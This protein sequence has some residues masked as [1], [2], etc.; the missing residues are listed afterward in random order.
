MSSKA[1]IAPT[2]VLIPRGVDLSR[3]CVL[4]SDQYSSVRDYWQSV[5]EY[6]GG[7]PSTLQMIVP[8]VYLTVESADELATRV[9]R[10][11]VAMDQALESVFQRYDNSVIYVERATER[12]KR[13]RSL[14]VG[15]DL[16]DYSFTPHEPA[17]I[18][19]SEETVLER[20]P[21]REAVRAQASVELPHVQVLF[22]DPL[23]RVFSFIDVAQETHDEQLQPVY[24]TPLMM[25]GGVVRG[26]RI[27]G[28]SVL[29]RNLNNAL[30]DLDTHG[31][32]FR[33]VVGDG[34]HS[35]AAARSHWL[36][37]K[38]AGAREDH[39]ARFALVELIEVH[40]SGLT[41]EPI[42]RW[43]RGV[44]EEDLRDAFDR[45]NAS[46]PQAKL[47]SVSLVCGDTVSEISVAQ[48]QALVIES[49]QNVIDEL[50]AVRNLDPSYACEY[51]HGDEEL[52][53]LVA[54]QGGVG[55]FLPSIDRSALFDYV[56]NRGVMPRKSFS[57]GEAEEKRYYLE[58]RR[59]I[60]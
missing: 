47:Q 59:I 11:R 5:E 38:K 51:I 4:A 3:W 32:G 13:R 40:D 52:K 23:N 44:S 56:A 12:V 14:L 16:E 35:L 39:P 8:E 36:K 58:G 17:D 20:I 25:G 50:I 7:Q 15:I 29:W 10:T 21:A 6:V 53:R 49:V 1:P 19:A 27:S 30:N 48:P 18:R 2:D 24:D 22:D 45:W 55:I 60:E 43:V 54:E 31:R 9:S 37:L 41:M 46:H 57:L 34:N 33:F 28:D 42:H 26:W